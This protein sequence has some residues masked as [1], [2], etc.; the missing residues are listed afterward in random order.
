MMAFAT[1]WEF[2]SVLI[3]KLEDGFGE[4]GGGIR[5]LDDDNENG[6]FKKLARVTIKGELIKL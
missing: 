2:F 5:L 4:Y 3:S 1:F 6:G